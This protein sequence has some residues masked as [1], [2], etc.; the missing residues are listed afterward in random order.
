[1]TTPYSAQWYE[2][3]DAMRAELYDPGS[4]AREQA[5]LDAMCPGEEDWV[6][7][8]Q[9]CGSSPTVHPTHL[10]GPCCFGEADTI[11]GNW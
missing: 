4:T 7:P 10:C 6:I 2:E 11:N 8:C 9:N 5:R 1:M 3:Q